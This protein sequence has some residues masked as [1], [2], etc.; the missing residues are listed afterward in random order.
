MLL[1][2][3]ENIKKIGKGFKKPTHEANLRKHFYGC[4]TWFSH[5]TSLTRDIKFH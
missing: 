4:D 3:D 1:F 5:S 2:K